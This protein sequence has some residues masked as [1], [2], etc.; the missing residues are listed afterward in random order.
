MFF[1]IQKTSADWQFRTQTR[2]GC[3]AYDEGCLWPRGK[4]LGGTSGLNGMLYVRGNSRDYDEWERLGNPTW[5]W[6]TAL[7]YFRKSE[8]NQ[9][10]T[11]M[12][13]HHSVGGPLKVGNLNVKDRLAEIIVSAA[14]ELG[15]KLVTDLNDDESLGYAYVQTVIHNGERESAAKAFLAPAKD[16]PNLHVI[17]YAYATSIRIGGDGVAEGV[18]FTYR[19]GK[20]LLARARKEIVVSA[21]AV[22]TP[23]LL[24][25][26]GIGPEK[27]LRKLNIPIK[28]DLAVG[29]NLQDHLI[30][31]M[32]FG[33]HRS[34]SDDVVPENL[35]RNM[36]D[37]VLHR[38]GPLAHL[39]STDMC[40][41]VNTENG[42]GYPDIETHHFSFAKQTSALGVYLGVVGFAD[43]IRSVLLEA[44]KNQNVITV[45]VVLLN[46][47]SVGK[48]KL[49]STN[50]ND[51]PLIRPNYLDDK[52][53]METLLRGVNYQHNFVTT[54]AFAAHEGNFI[55]LPIDECDGLTFGTDEYWRCYVLN[56]ATTVYHPVGTAK[57]GPATDRSAVVD[58]RLRVHGVQ[59]L[60]VIDASVMPKIVSGNTN[61]P[62]I[63]IGERGADFIKEDW[64]NDAVK[65]E[66]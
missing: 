41:F 61:A 62:T 47:I 6:P 15:Q 1:T 59:A 38:E 44:N 29:K 4:M 36:F 23:Q 63:M 10:A 5:N 30:V 35:A 20:K 32:F 56:M 21:G 27:H 53:D 43:R 40:G 7:K 24:L 22:S 64:S 46:P 12:G 55:Q 49:N 14:E 18:E 66:L 26:S 13:P 19:G 39:G 9:N 51:P 33:F 65:D 2:K 34:I 58:A 57:M 54:K 3:R 25:L 52:R 31:P 48:I 16:R 28:K 45:Y 37:Y 17:K 8:D 50:A 60:R 42:T 11:L